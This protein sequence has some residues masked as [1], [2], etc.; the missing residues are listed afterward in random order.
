MKKK[1]QSFISLTRIRWY[2][3]WVFT[4]PTTSPFFAPNA[5]FSNS[6]TIWPLRNQPRSPQFRP[7]GQLECFFAISPKSSPAAILALSACASCSVLTRTCEAD[8]CR[9]IPSYGAGSYKK[10]PEARPRRGSE[11]GDRGVRGPLLPGAD[12]LPA[13]PGR[14]GRPPARALHGR[15][16]D[17]G[18]A[19]LGQRRPARARDRLHAAPLR[20]D[21]RPGGRHARARRRR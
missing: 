19:L 4:G 12:P 1:P 16:H 3:N 2:P 15:G 6:G 18:L 8:T 17:R 21:P 11:D 5:A 9:G 10:C 14:L 20:P 7:D 13:D